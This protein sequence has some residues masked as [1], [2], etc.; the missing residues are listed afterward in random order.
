MSFK[1][2]PIIVVV[3]F[4]FFYLVLSKCLNCT[5]FEKFARFYH[6]QDVPHEFVLMN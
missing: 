1:F 2:G 5:A 6:M 3:L 4:F